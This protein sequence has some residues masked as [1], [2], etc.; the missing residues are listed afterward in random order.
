VLLGIGGDHGVKGYRGVEIHPQHL[1]V[2]LAG[3]DQGLESARRRCLFCGSDFVELL[4]ANAR[5]W[6]RRHALSEQC[7]CCSQQQAL[8]VE[9]ST[10]AASLSMT[11]NGKSRL[12]SEAVTQLAS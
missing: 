7:R 4:V 5:A 1:L 11:M 2:A 6:H 10:S 3:P 9:S 8:M 12:S